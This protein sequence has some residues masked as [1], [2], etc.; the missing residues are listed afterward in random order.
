MRKVQKCANPRYFLILIGQNF[1]K[2]DLEVNFEDDLRYCPSDPFNDD[3]INKKDRALRSAYHDKQ[4]GHLPAIPH[5]I[6]V[7]EEEEEHDA[8]CHH[9]VG[10]FHLHSTQSILSDL[11]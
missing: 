10:S 9:L 11:L 4:P 6:P 7:Q 5:S 8:P 2:V 3:H 1:Y